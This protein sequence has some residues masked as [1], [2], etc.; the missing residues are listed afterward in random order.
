MA[1]LKNKITPTFTLDWYI[2]WFSSVIILIGM[3]LTSNQIYPLNLMF[4]M[5]GSIGWLVVAL[6]WHD[7]SIMIINASAIMIM[8]NGLVQYFINN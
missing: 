5:V 4:S 1:I 6:I 3:V 7:R 2:K 8:S